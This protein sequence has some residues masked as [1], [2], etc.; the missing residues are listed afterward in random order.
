MIGVREPSWA[1]IAF[2]AVVGLTYYS[3]AYKWSFWA[4]V[5]AIAWLVV[6]A[7]LS[8]ANPGIVLE[9]QMASGQ[10]PTGRLPV[11]QY[12][13]RLILIALFCFVAWR[14]SNLTV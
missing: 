10:F 6:S 5:A 14:L 7:V 1:T 11:S 2:A 8:L 13:H 4:S 9:E 12:I 3:S